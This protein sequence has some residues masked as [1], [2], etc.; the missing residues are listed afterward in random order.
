MLLVP[1]M[2]MVRV[3]CESVRKWKRTH[4]RPL[5]LQVICVGNQLNEHIPIS[6]V[7]VD[8]MK[9]VT[10]TMYGWSVRFGGWSEGG[11]RSSSSALRPRRCTAQQK[12]LRQT[13]AHCPWESRLWCRTALSSSPSRT[14]A[15]H[16]AI[17]FGT[18]TTLVSLLNLS[19]VKMINWLPFFVFV[20]GTSV[21]I[22]I[23][24][25]GLGRGNSFNNCWCFVRRSM[26][27]TRRQSLTYFYK[28]RGMWDF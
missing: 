18:G 7:V 26:S 19:A 22:A 3:G 20:S 21:S 5:H 12:T 9:K 23:K 17:I 8:I 4:S 2:T 6:L 1:Q 25:H 27:S 15:T 10:N 28:S 24:D 11:T 16:R 13:G 14:F